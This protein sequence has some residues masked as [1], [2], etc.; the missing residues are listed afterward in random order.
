MLQPDEKPTAEAAQLKKKAIAKFKP[1]QYTPWRLMLGIIT[2]P[3]LLLVFTVQVMNWVYAEK[4]AQTPCQ[5]ICDINKT[6]LA[7]QL[8]CFRL[9][10]WML[11]GAQMGDSR[12]RVVCTGECGTSHFAAALPHRTP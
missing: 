4:F 2:V 10:P 6:V 11:T 8:P 7:G 12:V 1:E 9:L 3:L 5:G